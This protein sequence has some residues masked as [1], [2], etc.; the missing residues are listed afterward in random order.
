MRKLVQTIFFHIATRRIPKVCINDVF[1]ASRISF[2]FLDLVHRVLDSLSLV[3][4]SNFVFCKHCSFKSLWFHACWL[5][6][7]KYLY[8]PLLC[9]INPYWIFVTQTSSVP[10]R[11]SSRTSLSDL[12]VP[13]QCFHIILGL[14]PISDYKEFVSHPLSYRHF[15]HRDSLIQVCNRIPAEFAEWTN[16][17][18]YKMK[19]MIMWF[20][21]FFVRIKFVLF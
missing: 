20:Q 2:N 21:K 19:G 11:N 12:D 6:C 4:F 16:E 7:L 9:L 3:Y 13:L 10:L 14:Q 15:S 8:L 18:G 17:Q 1:K 5:F